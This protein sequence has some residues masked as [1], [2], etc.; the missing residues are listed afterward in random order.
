MIQLLE[1][2]ILRMI[3]NELSRLE[4]SAQQ[5]A[6]KELKIFTEMLFNFIDKKTEIKKE[7]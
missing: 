5:F 1:G 3:E 7:A 4:P 2:S 6:L